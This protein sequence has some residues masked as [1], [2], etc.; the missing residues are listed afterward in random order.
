MLSSM[1]RVGLSV[2]ANVFNEPGGLRNEAH[3]AI[4]T[5]LDQRHWLWGSARGAEKH[6]QRIRAGVFLCSLQTRNET[7]VRCASR[8]NHFLLY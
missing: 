7:R 5:V 2:T 6:L 1:L 3:A 4:E 8:N